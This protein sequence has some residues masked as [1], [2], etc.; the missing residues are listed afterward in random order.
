MTVWPD[1]TVLQ[2]YEPTHCVEYVDV[3]FDAV[4]MSNGKPRVQFIFGNYGTGK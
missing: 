4:F 1:K 2:F 3:K